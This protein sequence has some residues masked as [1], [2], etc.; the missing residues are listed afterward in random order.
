MNEPKFDMLDAMFE[1]N[2]QRLEQIQAY[3][4]GGGLERFLETSQAWRKLMDEQL[5]LIGLM[6]QRDE[7]RK[8]RQP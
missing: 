8:D 7:Q 4:N 3:A 2:R 6:H 1:V 5:H